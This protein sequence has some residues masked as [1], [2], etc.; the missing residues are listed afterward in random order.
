MAMTGKLKNRN[1]KLYVLYVYNEFAEP[2]RQYTWWRVLE[3]RRNAH[4]A[5]SPEPED[6][7]TY[8]GNGYWSA[9]SRGGV[10]TGDGKNQA[11]MVERVS[12]LAPPSRGKELRWHDGKWERLMAKG[13]VA[14]GEGKARPATRRGHTQDQT[15]LAKSAVVVVYSRPSGYWYAQAHDATTGAQIT[16]ASGYSREDVLN[17]LRGK[18]A[19]IGVTIKSITD[20]D[21]YDAPNRRS[22]TERSTKTKQQ[23]NREIEQATG[24]RVRG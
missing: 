15:R 9:G 24:I 4:N 13:W 20:E 3:V 21:P 7:V 1:G 11:E 17:A 16:D 22:S 5:L 10:V 6:E 14:A 12:V 8:R 23:L 19:M 2:F 18:F